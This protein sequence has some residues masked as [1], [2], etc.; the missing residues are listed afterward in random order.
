MEMVAAYCEINTKHKNTPCVKMAFLTFRAGSTETETVK[1]KL[2][3]KIA[4]KMLILKKYLQVAATFFS[5]FIAL[6]P[7]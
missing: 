2:C 3:I 4:I 7:Q 1:Y 5:Q 6:S